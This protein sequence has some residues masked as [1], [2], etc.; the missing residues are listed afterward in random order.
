MMKKQNEKSIGQILADRAV[1]D[2]AWKRYVEDRENNR[3]Q[4]RLA[5][6]IATKVLLYLEEDKANRSKAWLAE[7]MGV[8]PQHVGK[9]LKAQNAL[10]TT[11]IQKLEDATGLVL[12]EVPVSEKPTVSVFR[13]SVFE[14]IIPDPRSI[15]SDNAI[16]REAGCLEFA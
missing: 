6:K 2:T 4:Y 1:P 5:F 12:V 11:T 7:R 10:T 3:E 14:G 13:T 15:Y 8:S 9:I 16:D